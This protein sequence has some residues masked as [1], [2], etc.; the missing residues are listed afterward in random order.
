MAE[1]LQGESRL[2]EIVRL[3]GPDTLPDS[4]RFILF[5]AR[6][7]KESFLQQNAMHEI[8]A[9]T[10]PEKQAA[11]LELLAHVYERGLQII[12]KG[13]PVGRLQDEVTVWPQLRR[14]STTVP[15]DD[16]AA[17]SALENEIDTQLAR[18]EGEYTS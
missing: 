3:V 9:Y 1:I 17:I 4:Q 8:D 7:I 12:A 16:T 11:M 18:I 13:A 10:S 2:Q 14:L 5:V 15:N 6:L